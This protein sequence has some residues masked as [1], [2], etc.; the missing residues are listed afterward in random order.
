[1]VLRRIYGPVRR[2]RQVGHMVEPDGVMQRQ[3]VVPI[4]PGVARACVALD[5]ERRHSETSQPRTESESTLT[6][7]H[8]HDVRLGGVA[9]LRLLALTAL[10]PRDPVLDGAELH[11][12][13]SRVALLLLEAFQFLQG[14]EQRPGAPLPEPDVADAAPAR[15]LERDPGL[16]DSA[17]LGGLA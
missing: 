13:G 16:D 10:P 3:R 7:A 8:D 15:G 4:A 12:Q 14:G 11:P 17:N 5:D 6:A 9:Q 2:K 1:L